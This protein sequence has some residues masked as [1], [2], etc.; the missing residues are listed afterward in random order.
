MFKKSTETTLRVGDY[1]TAVAL[2][3]R[4]EET[5][6]LYGFLQLNPDECHVSFLDTAESAASTPGG[7][8]S[9]GGGCRA[10]TGRWCGMGPDSR[11]QGRGSGPLLAARGRTFAGVHGP[12]RARGLGVHYVDAGLRRSGA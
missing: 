7:L 6:A 2:P 5:L 11:S 3:G 9:H 8:G 4:L 12:R 1:V 10:F